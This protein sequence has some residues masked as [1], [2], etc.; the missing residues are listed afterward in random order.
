MEEN[1][2]S[3]IAIGDYI[4]KKACEK[5][6]QLTPLQVIKLVYLSHGWMLAMYQRPLTN[7][8]VEAWKYGPV[9][10][11]LYDAVKKFGSSPISASHIMLGENNFS[12][13]QKSIIDQVM[14]IY[15][16]FSGVQ[17]SAITHK[18]G[19]PWKQTVDKHGINNEV[20]GNDLIQEHFEC[21]KQN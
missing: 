2:H 11:N 10:G 20:I 17:L 6:R 21:L 15:K 18:E 4:I 7:E 3:A 19:T 13:E 8:Y 9:L 14:E 5:N 12:E 16:D 1:T